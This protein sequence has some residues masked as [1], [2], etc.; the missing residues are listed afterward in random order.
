[1]LQK[2]PKFLEVA[3]KTASCPKVAEQLEDRATFRKFLRTYGWY[4]D[5]LNGT[6]PYLGNSSEPP[7]KSLRGRKFG[8]DFWPVLKV[9]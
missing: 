8:C 3:Q 7:G 6:T 4:F 1:M 5:D 9:S 2:L